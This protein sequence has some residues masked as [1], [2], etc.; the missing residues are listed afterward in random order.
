MQTEQDGRCLFFTENDSD[1]NSNDE[2]QEFENKIVKNVAEQIFADISGSYS[3][4][5][6]LSKDEIRTWVMKDDKPGEHFQ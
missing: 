5:E 4:T 3:Q 2:N 6:E 1:S